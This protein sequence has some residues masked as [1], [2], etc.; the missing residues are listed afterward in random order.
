MRFKAMIKKFLMIFAGNIIMAI[1]VSGFILKANIAMGG[2]TGMALCLEHYFGLNISIGVLI[3]NIIMLL[4][5]LFT[6]GKSFVLTSLI[7]SFFYPVAL[8]II[9]QFPLDALT[10]DLVLIC[11]F[12]GVLIGVGTGLIFRSGTASGGVDILF[13]IINRKSGIP[14]SVMVYVF[15]FVI[16]AIQ[17]TFTSIEQILWGIIVALITSVIL[18]KVMIIGQQQTQVIIISLQFDKIG[19]AIQTRLNRGITLLNGVTGYKKQEQKV[20]L[21]VISN[22]QLVE[23]NQIIKDID[24]EAFIIINRVNEVRGEGFSFKPP[25]QRMKELQKY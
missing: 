2:T 8:S 19:E 10:N 6:L 24:P 21:S 3:V 18:N 11:L 22:R 13:V 7:S 4:V 12:G 25:A 16:L 20:I 5:G 17:I 15:D 1:G 9:E 23:V 14:L